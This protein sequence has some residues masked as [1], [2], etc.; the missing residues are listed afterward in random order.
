MV[1]IKLSRSLAIY[2]QQLKILYRSYQKQKHFQYLV[3]KT[4]FGK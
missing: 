4:D 3:Q 2:N 1:S